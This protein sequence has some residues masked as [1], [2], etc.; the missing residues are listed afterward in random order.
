MANRSRRWCFTLN[1]P[2][3]SDEKDIEL[4]GSE[5]PVTYLIAGDEKGENGTRH[6][7]GYVEFK[8]GRTLA[9]V[10]KYL[11]RAHWESAKGD[12]G[13]NRTYCSKE[14]QFREWG[15]ISNQGARTD[16]SAMREIIKTS[17]S[18]RKCIEEATSY[19]AVRMAEKIL[20]YTVV[21]RAAPPVVLWIF[22]KTG[23]G[24]TKCAWELNGYED[25]WAWNGSKWFDGYDGHDTVIF[26]DYRGTELPFTLM[27]RLLD[28]YPM[29]VEIK[30]GF[31]PWVAKTI[32]VTSQLSPE[33][34]HGHHRGEDLDQLLRR[35]TLVWNVERDGHPD[36]DRVR[37][38][39]GEVAG[40][41]EVTVE[42]VPNT[43]GQD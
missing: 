29:S 36:T 22:G 31:R 21:T 40:V 23:V 27:L 3:A 17:G 26:D 18:I 32:I 30:G 42:T 37:E 5:G 39:L 4:F 7:Q 33:D 28:R 11:P 8:N 25:T 9:G 16:L 19:Q 12:P 2:T 1:N 41:E 24:K 38:E 15:S 35:I 34:A 14:G 6:F 13:S 20:T 10:K 43:P